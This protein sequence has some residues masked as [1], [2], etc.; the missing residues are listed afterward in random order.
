M[1]IVLVHEIANV[2]SLPGIFGASLGSLIFIVGM[3]CILFCN[4]RFNNILFIGM[5]LQLEMWLLLI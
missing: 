1:D 5:D 2:A 3:K 4:W